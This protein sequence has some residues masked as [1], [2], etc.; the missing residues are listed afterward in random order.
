MRLTK[1]FPSGIAQVLENKYSKIGRV[2]SWLE[3]AGDQKVKIKL[4][5]LMRRLGLL[6]K[7]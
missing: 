1:A 7:K 4:S 2:F 6:P 5:I 3:P